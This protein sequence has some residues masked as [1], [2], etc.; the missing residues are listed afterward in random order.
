[1]LFVTVAWLAGENLRGRRA[2][3]SALEERA[4][5]LEVEREERARQAVTEE[6]MR[7][8]RELHDVVAHSM[9]VV[10]V[11]AG[12]AHHLI[13]SR[14][15]LAAEALAAIEET[16]RSAL[17]EMRRMLGVL[18]QPDEPG[19]ALTPA[20][21]LADLPV[22]VD[23]LAEAG[24]AVTV[25]EEGDAVAVP[26]GVDLSAY[27]VVQESLTNVL[28]HGGPTAQVL[29]SRTS[30]AVT[31]DVRRSRPCGST[32]PPRRRQ[33][34]RADRD[35]R[36]RRR[37]RWTAVGRPRTGR[38]L[39]G[40]RD[41][42]ADDPGAAVIRVLVVDDQALV[43]AGFEALVD[44]ADDLAVVGSATN[45]AE[46]VALAREHL[47]DVVLMDIRMP[48]MD[49]LEATATILGDPRTSD[50]RVLILTTFDLDEYVFA[51]LRSGASGFLLK[52]TRPVDLLEG[53]R[54]VA[55]GEALLSPGV[56]RQLIEAYVRRPP[57]PLR[58]GTAP[59]AGGAHRT[60]AR[61]ARP[62][63]T[64]T[65][66]HRD[67][68]P[69]RG[70]PGHRQDTHRPVADEARRPGPCAARRGCLRE[71]VGDRARAP[72]NARAPGRWT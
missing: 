1:M 13:A 42:A 44:S 20:P 14:P 60:R 40:D 65:L 12:T 57:D 39:P 48:V 54:V 16:S 19:A 15:G 23:Q 21:G 28:R 37:L 55:G 32:R 34:P 47:P 71:R 67:R 36:T 6:R 45:G 3:W 17:V 22:L 50:V 69:A 72:V 11:Q 7:I 49:G 25:R 31:V 68:R 5:A 46:A 33:R 61:G 63:R 59:G 2:R 53:I 30:D 62:G 4:R 35:A 18:R 29:L 26:P 38:W 41:A 52:D 56:T 70:Q 58:T 10:A 9:S 27:R 24:L 66:E 51:A 64:G 43:R 8:A